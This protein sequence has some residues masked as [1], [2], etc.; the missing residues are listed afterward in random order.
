MKLPTSHY[1]PNNCAISR[2]TDSAHARGYVPEID[3]RSREVNRFDWLKW[4]ERLPDDPRADRAEGAIVPHVTTWQRTICVAIGVD[5]SLVCTNGAGRRRRCGRNASGS[6][7]GGIAPRRHRRSRG[8]QISPL[9]C[10]PVGIAGYVGLPR[11]AGRR[12]GAIT[13]VFVRQSISAVSDFMNGDLRGRA[14]GRACGNRSAG[15]SILARIDD[16]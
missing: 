16:A 13:T 1:L 9:V 11:F 5:C 4:L 14:V 3:A 2:D 8:D 7:T 15:A 10:G 12:S 6:Y